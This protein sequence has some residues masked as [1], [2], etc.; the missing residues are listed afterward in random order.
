MLP[1]TYCSPSL[2]NA[3]LRSPEHFGETRSVHLSFRALVRLH[4]RQI[5][6]L[7]HLYIILSRSC[8]TTVVT[9]HIS[10]GILLTFKARCLSAP[11]VLP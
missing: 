4:F 11:R 2:K 8:S 6:L 1:Y 5:Q 3:R 9:V 10:A 7:F